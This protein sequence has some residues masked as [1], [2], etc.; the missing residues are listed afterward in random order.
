MARAQ[1]S[2]TQNNTGCPTVTSSDRWPKEAGSLLASGRYSTTVGHSAQRQLATAASISSRRWATQPARP[3]THSAP[4]LWVSC[5][6]Q[7]QLVGPTPTCKSFR[8]FSRSID[9]RC[10]RVSRWQPILPSGLNA[11]CMMVSVWP[12]RGLPRGAAAVPESVRVVRSH[13][14]KGGRGRFLGNGQRPPH[15]W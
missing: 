15:K 7:G 2:M 10:R 14:R 11:T 9:A 3:S 4:R 1:H 12:A 5:T 8:G 13:S 6:S